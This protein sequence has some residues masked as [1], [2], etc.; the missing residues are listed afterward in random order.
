LKQKKW[1]TVKTTPFMSIARKLWRSCIRTER[2]TRLLQQQRRDALP[3]VRK[4]RS[5]KYLPAA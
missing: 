3:L 2:C 5:R 4:A 1:N